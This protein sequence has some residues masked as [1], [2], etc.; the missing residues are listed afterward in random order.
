MDDDE[1]INHVEDCLRVKH[2]YKGHTKR[3]ILKFVRSKLGKDVKDRQ[4][5]RQIIKALKKA[6]K[7][8]GVEKVLN[9]YFAPDKCG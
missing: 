9:I 8:G 1:L 6:V 7:M 4:A 3:T 2:R 5:T